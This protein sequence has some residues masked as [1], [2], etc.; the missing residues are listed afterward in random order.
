MRM[1][2]QKKPVNLSVDAQ[3]LIEAKQHGV[4][5]S[6]LLERALLAEAASRWQ[7]ENAE[8]IASYNA[9]ID[10]NGVWSDGLREW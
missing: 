10:K 1:G 2:I 5:L 6:A 9:D 3:L 7:S 4:N 8:A